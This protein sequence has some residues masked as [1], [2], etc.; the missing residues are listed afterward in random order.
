MDDQK[1]IMNKHNNSTNRKVNEINTYQQTR[2]QDFL[3]L[4][5]YSSSDLECIQEETSLLDRIR[6]DKRRS[7]ADIRSVLSTS[8]SKPTGK[9]KNVTFRDTTTNNEKKLW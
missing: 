1:A 4:S 5:H 3:A 2:D 6:R 7:Q 9:D 8:L